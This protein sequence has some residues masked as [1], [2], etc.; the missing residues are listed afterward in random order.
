MTID[1][2]TPDSG[3]R[4][5]RPPATGDTR[6]SLLDAAEA[7]FAREGID[8]ASLRAITREAGANLASVHY[9]FGSKDALV[10]AVFDRRLAP[11]N[12]ERLG[13]LDALEEHHGPDPVPLE[14]L[15]RAFI[16]PVMAMLK[17]GSAEEVRGAHQL[18]RL[19]VRAMGDPDRHNRAFVLEVF[20]EVK[21]R[22]LAALGRTLDLPAAELYWRFHFMTGAMAHTA[23]SG[24]LV[25]DLSGGL[26]DASDVD[27]TLE[28]LITFLAAGLRAPAQGT[29]GGASPAPEDDR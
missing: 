3:S 27:G 4:A 14:A 17:E 25:Q 18:A 1:S 23:S 29:A 6:D 19:V 10:R 28:H 5:H 21:D 11:L 12:A 16:E 8:G 15:L 2:P 7:L 24:Y 9:H 13:A 20:R 22:F 26:C